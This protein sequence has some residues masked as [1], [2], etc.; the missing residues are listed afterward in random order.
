M[1]RT[2]GHVDDV[3]D[4]EMKEV[5]IG[6]T[7]VLLVRTGGEYRA[8][9]ARCPHYGAPLVEG[10]L[11]DGRITCP[12]H[13]ACFD[14]HTGDLLE[15][16]ALDALAS[17]PVR[18]DGDEVK[19]DL[20]SDPPDRRTLPAGDQRPATDDVIAI[21]G[22][23]AA[24]YMAAQTLRECGD[25]RR[26]VM[27]TPESRLPYDRPNLSKDYLH[28][29][30]DPAWMP[31]RPD[32]FYDEHAI[33]RLT[34]TRVRSLRAAD[35]TIVLDDGRTIEYAAAVIATGCAPRRL[36]VPGAD[37]AN[38]FT[39]RSF[40][41]ADAII[42][43][44]GDAKRAVVVGASFIA[45]EAASS[46]A[47]RGVAVTVVA[48]DAVPFERTLGRE[49]GT[50]LQRTHEANGVQFRLGA[51]VAGCEGGERVEAVVLENGEQ[52][53]CDLVVVGIGVTPI[54]DFIDGV[55][56]DRDRGIVV[57]AHLR[58]ADNLYAAGDIAAY[59]D[60]RNGEP[61]RIEHWRT[62][63]QLG[64]IA[65][66]NLAGIAR[67]VDVVPFFWTAQFDTTL[68]YVGHARSW[69][70]IVYRGDVEKGDFV[71]YYVRDGRVHAAVTSGRDRD[72][73]IIADTIRRKGL[74]TVDELPQ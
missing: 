3:K 56:R 5:A 44:C 63:L 57:D 66:S 41:D 22:G 46:L 37:L 17:Y 28:G 32:E 72:A 42:R 11:S 54:T 68:R 24:G 38:V 25:A 29:H 30:A 74:P 34:N 48:P 26:I 65:G 47:T 73:T 18:V 64:R 40:D 67:P 50:R 1:E 10:L 35:R 12:W 55:E 60:P 23:G 58:A 53:A 15:P 39:L 51:S 33:E 49:I 14:A 31:L 4:G 7:P 43:S 8:F 62:A 69:D 70:E 52:L 16:P 9:S 19:V 13:H 71:A 59:P 20:P 45:M 2:V 27:I 6:D 21:V 36:E 61:I